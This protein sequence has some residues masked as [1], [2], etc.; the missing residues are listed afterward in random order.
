MT[1]VSVALSLRPLPPRFQV[2][3]T[4]D[5]LAALPDATVDFVY[6]DEAI[7]GMDREE[8]AR[9]LWQIARILTPKG[10]LRLAVS[11]LD[12]IVAAYLLDWRT[13][14]TQSRVQRLNSRF[15]P[16][17]FLF[18]EEELTSCLRA[19]GFTAVWR[20]L[21]CSSTE[22]LLTGLEPEGEPFRLVLEARK[23]SELP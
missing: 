14:P 7:E 6:C 9:N 22:P 17:I 23:A 1:A 10:V 4:G 2:L 15:R 21:P 12:A 13:E 16:G 8:L 19:A 5:G 18:N 20:Y 3:P 11:D